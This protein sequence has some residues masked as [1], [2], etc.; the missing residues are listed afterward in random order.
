MILIERP[1]DVGCHVYANRL[2][3]INIIALDEVLVCAINTIVV[4]AQVSLL[5][6][7]FLP[8]TLTEIAITLDFDANCFAPWF[9][10]FPNLTEF[11]CLLSGFL[12]H[13]FKPNYAFGVRHEAIWKAWADRLSR[14][15]R[16][17][18]VT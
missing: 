16:F 18:I 5:T 1:Q 14:K 17:N 8:D 10:T 2:S 7:T 9:V 13:L 4:R 11:G 3:L 15:P 6:T 12:K